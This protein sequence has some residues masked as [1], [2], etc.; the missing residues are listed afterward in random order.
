MVENAGLSFASVTAADDHRSDLHEIHNLARN[1]LLTVAV[2][3]RV[4]TSRDE[5]GSTSPA[6]CSL[7]PIIG[8]R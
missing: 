8:Y 3:R 6:N 7:A 2:G 1:R 4:V 5:N